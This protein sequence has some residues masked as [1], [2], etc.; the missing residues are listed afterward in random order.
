MVLVGKQCINMAF[1]NG[2]ILWK[3]NIKH[4]LSGDRLFM[5]CYDVR[6]RCLGSH[7]NYSNRGIDMLDEWKTDL[8]LMYHYIKSLPGYDKTYTTKSGKVRFLTLDRINNDGNYEPGNLRWTD[9]S[10]QS[11]NQRRDNCYFRTQEHKDKLKRPKSEEHKKHMSEA[12]LGR[13]FPKNL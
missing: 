9:M 3:N 5:V 2:N 4:G 13:K 8:T 7:P 1:K 11:I 12:R 6:K 10:T